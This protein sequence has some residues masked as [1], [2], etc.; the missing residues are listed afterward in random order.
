MS[1]SH[2]PAL[3]GIRTLAVY[4]VV[5]FHCGVGWFGAGYLG[6]DLFFVLSGFLVSSILLDEMDRTGKLRIGNFYGRRVRR[7]LP[8]A[9]VVVVATCL[10][11]LLS[12]STVQRIPWVAD[13]QASLLYA[14]NWRFLYQ[15]NDYFSADIDKSPFLHFWSLSIEEQFY[16]AFPLILVGLFALRRRWRPA[17]VTGLSVLAALSLVSQAYWASHDTNHAYYG[18]DARI[19][20]LLFGAL[21]AVAWRRMA[22]HAARVDAPSDRRTPWSSFPAP[23]WLVLAALVVTSSGI[24]SF[25]VSLRGI[26]AAVLSVGLIMI[27]MTEIDRSVVRVLSIPAV[28]YLGRISYGTYLWH[29]PVLLAC[30]AVF[31]IGAWTTTALVSGLATALAAL[32]YEIL[33]TPIRQSRRLAP[34]GMRTLAVGV[35]CSAL[36]AATVVPT[37]LNED[38]HPALRESAAY[39]RG[40][41]MN[42]DEPVPSDIDWQRYKNDKGAGNSVCTTDDMESC[43]VNHGDSGLNVALIGD[44][45]ARQLATVMTK[46][47]KE[48]DFTLSLNVLGGCPWQ[49]G[50]TT[51]T[52]LE[53]TNESCGPSRKD[54]Y[55]SILTDMGV[56]VVILSQSPRDRSD[57]L[58]APDGST[59]DVAHLNLRTMQD[60]VDRLRGLGI[61][62]IIVRSLIRP[63]AET[64]IDPLDCLSAARRTAEC[65]VP[66]PEYASPSDA[67]YR[68]LAIDH[69][70][71]ATVDI[72]PVMCPAWPLCDAMQGRIPIWRDGG[73]YSSDALRAHSAGIWKVLDSTNFLGPTP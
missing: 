43:I 38:R 42:T 24:V 13:G 58:R 63:S 56:D 57:Q 20:Q 68:V 25:S 44:S 6:V 60:T 69:P 29:W 59:V 65:R 10:V 2:R 23:G 54:L 45:H 52:K 46:L 7:L 51:P 37:V 17:L 30:T 14:A 28:T 11:T 67:I 49:L 64:G 9:L 18:T 71:T 33:E 35:A 31:D 8:A 21:A 5:L 50:V 22:T 19:Y 32:S 3:D 12:S 26:I 15:S 73:H 55:D 27:V 70:D 34:F 40:I 41:A 62:V 4:L 47:A 53:R 72:N 61:K 36:L 39:I 1:W 48:H 16:F 66:A